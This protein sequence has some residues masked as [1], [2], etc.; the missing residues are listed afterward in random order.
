VEE[1]E[2]FFGAGKSG[3]ESGQFW[4]VPLV[5]GRIAPRK[6]RDDIWLDLILKTTTV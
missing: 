3:P 4:A 2:R 5:R 6:N 1:Q